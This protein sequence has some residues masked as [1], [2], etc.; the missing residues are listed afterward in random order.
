MTALPL[1]P[2]AAVAALC[3]V[4]SH[5]TNFIRGEHHLNVLSLLTT[6]LLFQCGLLVG[7]SGYL[8]LPQLEAFR[9][10][11]LLSSS[12]LGALWTSMLVYRCFFH[13]L[14]DWPGPLG[15]RLSMFYHVFQIRKLDQYKY[16]QR[17]HEKYGDFVRIG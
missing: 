17:L 8:G 6:A 3:G 2:F 15:A 5:L 11:T 9:I 14:R 4:I 10:V 13:P 7:L 12:Y 1:Y 16:L